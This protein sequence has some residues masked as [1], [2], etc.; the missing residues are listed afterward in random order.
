MAKKT[1]EKLKV[2]L[3]STISGYA[4]DVVSKD[5][6]TATRQAY[7]R[8]WVEEWMPKCDCY[9][10]KYVVEENRKG[11]K[12]K[13]EKRNNFNAMFPMIDVDE[14]LVS[15]LA[16]KLL[17]PYGQIPKDEKTDAYHIA[18]AAIYKMDIVLTWNFRH[19]RNLRILPATYSQIALAGYKCPQIMTPQEF[20]EA[21]V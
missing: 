9:I 13:A 15:V 3:E 2:Y 6:L 4:T 18:T 20:M 5:P 14:K 12:L 19:I 1:I 8:A 11:N 10:S 21:Y 17:V 7:T 16:Q